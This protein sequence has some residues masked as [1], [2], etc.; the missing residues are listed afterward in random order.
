MKHFGHF[1]MRNRSNWR[2]YNQTIMRVLYYFL[3]SIFSGVMELLANVFLPT[4]TSNKIVLRVFAIKTYH[5]YCVC[6]SPQRVFCVFHKNSLMV[7]NFF[8]KFVLII[9]QWPQLN[10]KYK[11]SN[12]QLLLMVF[13]RFIYPHAIFLYK[14]DECLIQSQPLFPK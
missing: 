8:K 6:H 5:Y 2:S 9:L 7:N 13:K 14:F 4:M 1:L 11:K 12:G 3:I 10:N